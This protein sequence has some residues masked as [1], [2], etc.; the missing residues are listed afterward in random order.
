MAHITNNN[1]GSLPS[2]P[3]RSYI[4]TEVFNSSFYSYTTAF[5]GLVFNGTLSSVPSSSVA[6]CP[7][8]RILHETGKKLFP[9]ANPGITDYMVS[10]FDPISML[11]GFINPNNANFSLMNTDRAAFLL[12][13]VTGSNAG[14]SSQTARANALYTRGDVLAGGRLDL[15]GN[16][17]I[18]GN[19][20]IG[21]S[22]STM[23][24]EYVA[25]NVRIGG[26][27]STLGSVFFGS[28]LSTLGN[29][30][31]SSNV[32]IGGNLSTLGNVFFGSNVSTVGNQSFTSNVNISGNLSTLGNVFFGSNVSTIGHQYFASTVQIS[33]NL[34][35]IGNVFLGSN[36]FQKNNGTVGNINMASGNTSSTYKQY[37]VS[38]PYVRT[39]SLIFLTY[40]NQSNA[41]ILS[42]DQIV[43]A[44]TFRIA[45]SSS[46]DAGQVNWMI[47]NYF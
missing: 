37:F 46:T 7:S 12:D 16:A 22:L 36:L 2:V 47:T 6:T 8:G 9:G 29:A 33:G 23:G 10:V 40:T 38:T 32:R 21:G 17:T 20:Y 30:V 35:T 24:N 19:E 34:S 27:L 15:S 3:R 26:N 44:S 28:S 42:T 11:T 4:S 39:N 31:F 43:P 1:N 41:G 13:N 14:L 25:G 18:Y 5:N 45:S